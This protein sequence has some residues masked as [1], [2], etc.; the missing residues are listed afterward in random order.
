M[1]EKQ[2]EEFYPESYGIKG[3]YEILTIKEYEKQE[4]EY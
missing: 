1:D 2:L 3:T 4:I